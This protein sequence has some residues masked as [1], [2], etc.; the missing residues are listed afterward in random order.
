LL[1]AAPIRPRAVETTWLP[2]QMMNRSVNEC[3]I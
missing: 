1:M 3:A 2:Y